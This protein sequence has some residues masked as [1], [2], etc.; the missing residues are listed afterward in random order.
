MTDARWIEIVDDI[1]KAIFHFRSSI[2]LSDAGGF[3]GDGLDGY[4]NRMALMH[5]M[6]S[7]YTSLEAGLE[8]I[9]E[10]L[11]EE[12]PIGSDYHAALLRRLHLPI[13]GKRPAFFEEK[14]YAAVDEARRFRHVARKSYDDLD[15]ERAQPA[16]VAVKTIVAELAIAVS[17]FRQKLEESK[18]VREEGA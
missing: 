2:A 13:G 5:S 1:E 14:L 18:R 12:K 15:I 10:L 9:L 4:R 17:G 16:L 11:D 6:Q 8:R 3:E 7:A